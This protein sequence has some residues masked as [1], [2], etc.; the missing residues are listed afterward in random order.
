MTCTSRYTSIVE[1]VDRM[2]VSA[3]PSKPLKNVNAI[4][5]DRTVVLVDSSGR[6]YSTQV[7]GN[8]AH[9]ASDNSTSLRNTITGA[10]RLGVISKKAMEMDLK[11]RQAYAE[12]TRREW[13]AD[14]IIEHANALGLRLTE[15]QRRRIEAA[16]KKPKDQ[17]A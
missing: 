11:H 16:Q 15:A 14:Q 1:D 17:T 3:I 7:Q 6:V 2:R 9:T 13:A 8:F 12:K 10:S 5:I 4:R